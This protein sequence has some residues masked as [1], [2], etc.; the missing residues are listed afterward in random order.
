MI[1]II[2]LF[3]LAR[4]IGNMAQER[5]LPKGKWQLAMV[6]AW[7]LFEIPGII[8][9]MNIIGIQGLVTEGGLV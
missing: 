4:Q 6:L 8:I 7:F 9:G 5:G 1:E 2:A 3:F